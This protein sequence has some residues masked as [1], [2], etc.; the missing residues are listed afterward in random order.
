MVVHLQV[1]MFQKIGQNP[2]SVNI[3]LKFD[4]Q[5]HLTVR[6]IANICDTLYLT[7]NANFVQTLNELLLLLT[8]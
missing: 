8:S 6:F 1:S 5:T 3:T 4:H 7:L 2:F